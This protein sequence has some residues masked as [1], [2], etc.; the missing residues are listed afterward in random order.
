MNQLFPYDEIRKY[1]DLLIKDIDFALQNK[2]NIIIHAPTGMG[3]TAAV[4]PLALAHALE[5]DL[6]VFFLTSRHT[7]HK[8]VLETLQQLKTK[9]KTKFLTADIIGKKMMCLQEGIQGL[10]SSEFSEY[11]KALKE[12]NKCNFFNNVKKK[13]KIGKAIADIKINDPC[14]VEELKGICGKYRLCPYEV[15]FILTK[16]AKVIIGDYNYLFHPMIRK[17]FLARSGKDLA[18]SIIIIDEAHNLPNRVREELSSKLSNFI[19]GAAIKEAR[20]YN[21]ESVEEIL[22]EVR[23][24]LDSLAAN[25]ASEKIVTKEEF[26]DKLKF[27]LESTVDILEDTADEIRKLQK[28]SFI[29]SVAT[30]LSLWSGEDE[31]FI[32][33]MSKNYFKNRENITLSYRCLDPSFA[34]SDVVNR[35]YATIAMSGTLTPTKMY[36]DLLGF[37]N[38]IEK[39]YSS[40]FPKKNR[41]DI[42]IPKTTTKYSERNEEQFKAISDIIVEVVNSVPGNIAVFFPSYY[43]RDKIYKNLVFLV[44]KTVFREEPGLSNN[45]KHEMLEKFKGYKDAGAVLLGVSA[46]S[47]GEGIDLPGDLL[48]AVVVVGLPLARPDL[49]T[50]GLID[51]YDKKFSMGWD[52]GYLFPAFNKCLQSAG[53]CIR[54]EKDKGVV[55]F[56]DKRFTWMNYFRCFPNDLNLTISVDYVNK[57]NEFFKK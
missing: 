13:E 40:P 16:E 33:I 37:E 19:L 36:K 53:R 27:D 45:E 35:S 22:L 47:F 51:Y 29:G 44:K 56:L 28:R 10:Y 12:D 24:A 1:Q 21:Y 41:L 43:F 46:G 25:L 30:F 26:L 17:F 8:I 32:R 50:K 3:K 23:Y 14:S 5:K 52:Y 38:V 49:E 48:K 57:I 18:Q 20:K 55:V 54:S 15:S 2:K 4:L 6:T 34:T 11:C 39:E 7:Q 31:G 42:I 9:H